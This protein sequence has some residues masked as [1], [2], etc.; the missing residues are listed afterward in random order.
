MQDV[1][2]FERAIQ[3]LFES[4]DRNYKKILYKVAS[5]HPCA[6]VEAV[7]GRQE[8]VPLIGAVGFDDKNDKYA[9]QDDL[10]DVVIPSGIIPKDGFVEISPVELPIEKEKSIETDII[11]RLVSSGYTTRQIADA[12]GVSHTTVYKWKHKTDY[13]RPR[14]VESLVALLSGVV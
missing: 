7:D 13:P 2:Y 11:D 4:N 12:A 5:M 6:L 9:K 8:D 3:I 1:K 14:R 10:A